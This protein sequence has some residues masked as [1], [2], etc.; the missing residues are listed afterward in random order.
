MGWRAA[1]GHGMIR[2]MGGARPKRTTT[3]EIASRAFDVLVA[4]LVLLVVWPVR[5]A[6]G[7]TMGSPVLF[8]Q[9]RAGRHGA[10]FEFVKFR[11]MRTAQPGDDGP[12]ADEARPTEVGGPLRA[13]GLDGLPPL[14]ENARGRDGPRRAPTAADPFPAPLL[15]LP[16]PPSRGA[17]GHHRV[18]PGP[19]TQRPDLGRP[20]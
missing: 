5:G 9:Q 7:L 6:I 14:G 19:R 15:G 1:P 11:T 12:D 4:G 3:P 18:G 13:T 17:A 20:A 10:T 8:R 16:C 2:T